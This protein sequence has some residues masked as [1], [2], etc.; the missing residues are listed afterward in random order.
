MVALPLKDFELTNRYGN[1]HPILK[2]GSVP[3]SD[4]VLP[5]QVLA[6]HSHPL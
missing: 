3:G 2:L 5:S 6:A 4:S 1:T